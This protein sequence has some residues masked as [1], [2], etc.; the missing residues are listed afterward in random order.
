MDKP[1]AK[2]LEVDRVIAVTTLGGAVFPAIDG[3]TLFGLRAFGEDGDD[4]EETSVALIFTPEELA[5]VCS[6][7][8]RMMIDHGEAD[9]LLA[10]WHAAMLSGRLN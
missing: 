3:G 9:V 5:V 1:R 6:K 10:A 2:A 7:I 8:A 4:D